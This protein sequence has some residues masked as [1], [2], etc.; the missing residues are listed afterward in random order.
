MI[1]VGNLFTLS[2]SE[3]I[4]KIPH[5]TLRLTDGEMSWCLGGYV[6]DCFFSKR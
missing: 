4:L 6:G 3:R 5:C 1:S 2:G